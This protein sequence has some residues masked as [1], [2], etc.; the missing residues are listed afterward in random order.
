MKRKLNTELQTDR[1]TVKELPVDER[2]DEKC[3]KYGPQALSDAE[4][5]AAVI[6]VGTRDERSV[7]LACRVL[8]LSG[9]H[10]GLAGLCHLNRADLLSLKGIG[11]VKA[12]QIMCIA[13]LSR[14][15]NRSQR[16]QT[17]DFRE[18]A[19]VADYYKEDMRHLEQEELRAVF[20]DVKNRLIYD[21]RIFYGTVSRSI[22]EPR[23]ILIEALRAG[24]SCLIILH[25]HPSGD[26]TPSQDDILA[27]T[28]L[29]SCCDLIGIRFLDHIV[30][31][32]NTYVSM[33]D[34][35]L[36]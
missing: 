6:R 23:E 13:E 3:L 19:S 32:D 8:K 14:R 21:R 1:M 12:V 16:S 4:L 29:K 11:D 7:E 28:R 2:P 20:L 22:A 18:S 17:L 5:L 24:A 10:S 26:P 27:T 33:K 25:N 31:G 36:F 30:I 15:L 35:G 34:A 9:S